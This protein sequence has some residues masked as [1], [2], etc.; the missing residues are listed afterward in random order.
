MG[1]E[2]EIEDVAFD[3]VIP[4]ITSGKADMGLAGMTVTEDRKVSVDFSILT[5]R[6]PR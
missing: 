5:Q 3:S 1:M 4:E 2:L 6:H